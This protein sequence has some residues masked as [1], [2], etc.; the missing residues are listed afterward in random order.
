MIQTLVAERLPLSP[1]ST[2]AAIP[3]GTKFNQ[4]I[5]DSPPFRRQHK[6]GIFYEC[7]C[8]CGNR[9]TVNVKLLIRGLTTNISAVVSCGCV[10]KKCGTK[11][12]QQLATQRKYCCR[13]CATSDPKRFARHRK[14]MCMKCNSRYTDPNGDKRRNNDSK[15]IVVFLRARFRTLKS[16]KHAVS[17]TLGYLVDLFQAQNGKCA[18]SGLQMTNKFYSLYAVSIDRINSRQ[19]Y[20][21]GNVQLVCSCMNLAKREHSDNEIK[22]FLESYYQL[23]ISD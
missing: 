16:R 5:I 6:H 14:T 15:D 20:I 21:I 4:L 13:N 22:E 17:I 10:G 3:I 9:P 7:K 11:T 18:I 23:R 8:V 12:S 1:F 2:H 19:G